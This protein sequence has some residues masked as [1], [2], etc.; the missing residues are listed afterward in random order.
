MVRARMR[1]RTRRKS[2]TRKRVLAAAGLA[3]R[4]RAFTGLV[5]PSFALLGAGALVGTVAAVLLVPRSG[6]ELRRDLSQGAQHLR[7]KLGD[8]RRAIRSL[9]GESAAPHA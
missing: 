3:K 8:A 1:S 7:R 6:S 9:A 4:R 5:L 2:F